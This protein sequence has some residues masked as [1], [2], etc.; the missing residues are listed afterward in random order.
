MRPHD[1]LQQYEEGYVEE[2]SN[3]GS[4]RMQSPDQREGGEALSLAMLP[5][6]PQLRAALEE[7]LHSPQVGLEVGVLCN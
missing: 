2:E 5:S 7:G 4:S 1:D 3:L 6:L